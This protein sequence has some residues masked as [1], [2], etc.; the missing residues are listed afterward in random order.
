MSL[1]ADL[2]AGDALDPGYAA[3]ARRRAA[4]ENRPAPGK[5]GKPGKRR[6]VGRAG[7]SVM[8]ALTGLLAAM[9]VLQVRRQE[10]AAVKERHRL[11]AEIRDRTAASDALE[12]RLDAV[13]D[14]TERA[15]AAA[16]ARSAAGRRARQDLARAADA[17]AATERSGPGLTV[18]VDD[19]PRAA[20]SDGDDGATGTTDSGLVY[21]QDLQILVNGLWGVGAGAIAV[22]GRRLTSTTAIRAAG[23]AIL[24][25]YR[26]LSPPYEVTALGGDRLRD[27]FDRSAAAEHLRSLEDQFGIRFDEHGERAAAL[28]A[29]AP[30]RL[31]YAREER[32]R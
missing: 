11:I 26:P 18:T 12:R 24:V 29:A 28:P 32:P 3:A 6:G 13:R 31:R 16:L 20:T 17:A 19:A 14:E 2:F 30:P 27:A 25:D 9:A 15:R 21:D 8:L 10:P 1:L 22:N 7:V 4:A 5:P 23:D